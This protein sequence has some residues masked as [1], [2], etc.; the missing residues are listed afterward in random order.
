MRERLLLALLNWLMRLGWCNC[1][2]YAWTMWRLYG[3]YRIYRWTRHNRW[4]WPRWK[5][6]MWAPKIGDLSVHQYVP[7]DEK[8]KPVAPPLFRGRVRVGPDE[9]DA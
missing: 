3:G 8:E 1:R 6:E 9:E 7:L 4:R 2:I 5:H